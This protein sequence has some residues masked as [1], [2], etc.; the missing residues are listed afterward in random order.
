MIRSL[1]DMLN[2]CIPF[3]LPWWLFIRVWYEWLLYSSP[4]NSHKIHLL[5]QPQVRRMNLD[6]MLLKFQLVIECLCCYRTT[7]PLLRRKWMKDRNY[8]THDGWCWRDKAEQSRDKVHL[9]KPYLPFQ[10]RL[11]FL[12]PNYYFW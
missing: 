10:I 6:S 1:V 5:N 2:E 7:F 9:L 4:F 8:L 11:A 3:V 12:L